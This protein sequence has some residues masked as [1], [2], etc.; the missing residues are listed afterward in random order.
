MKK[1]LLSLSMLAAV[2]VANAQTLVPVYGGNPKNTKDSVNSVDGFKTFI[3]GPTESIPADWSNTEDLDGTNPYLHLKGTGTYYVWGTSNGRYVV[4][5]GSPAGTAGVLAPLGYSGT[6]AGYV[7]FRAKGLTPKS[8]VKIAFITVD[9]KTFGGEVELYS[10]TNWTVENLPFVKLS[11]ENATGKKIDAAG[12]VIADPD[13]APGN[14]QLVA[15]TT[16]QVQN[17]G[18]INIVLNVQSCAW[19]GTACVVS[20]QP[21]DIWIDDVYMSQNSLTTIPGITVVTSTQSAAA[22]IASTKVY[23][24]PT[25]GEFTAEVSLVNNASVS[26]ILTDMMGK[27]IATKSATNGS[28]SFDTAGLAKGMYT[29]TYVLDG[30]PA[31]TELVVV[32]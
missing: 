9:G 23:P 19:N 5:A 32:K 24:N 13:N 14:T 21:G 12:N 4:P 8:K 28:V 15:P 22:N 20:A 3:P 25:T 29:V 2:M 6:A 11:Q 1:V 27:Q 18:Q 30:T 10:V 31:K 26:I 16:A 17:F 7:S